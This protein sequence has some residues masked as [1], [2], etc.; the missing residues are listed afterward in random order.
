MERRMLNVRKHLL[1]TIIPLL[2]RLPLPLASRIVAGIGRSEYR[3]A[4]KL[5]VAFQEAVERA[6][7]QLGCDWDIET[8]SLD[9]AGN[10]VWWRTRDLLLDGVPDHR[11]DPMFLVTGREHLDSA[12]AEGRGVIML[13]SH[14]G[15]HLLPAHWLAR[16]GYTLRFFM[17]RPRHV[18]RFLEKQFEGEGPLAQDKLFISRKGDAT[19]SAGS[20]LRASR[21]LSA[22]MILYLAGDVRW[23]GAHT[24]PGRFL[25]RQFQFS[26]TWVNLAAMTGAPVVPTFCHMEPRGRYLIQ[27]HP[28]YQIP[29][30]TI[31]AGESGLW[32][33]K[34]L[35]LLEEEV[36]LDPSN[37]NE[38]FF[39]P[40]EKTESAA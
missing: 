35:E 14:F 9:L 25:G 29:K 31:H 1:R 28:A 36:R 2:R 30:E 20:I 17:E 23:T 26:A 19:G 12:L 22:G 3:M 24:Q 16:L 8:V 37:S 7:E 13:T 10:Q 33:Q 34:F 5:R 18:S 4:P 21:A 15:G 11:A 27:F 32:V 40:D 39:W 38:Y 6:S